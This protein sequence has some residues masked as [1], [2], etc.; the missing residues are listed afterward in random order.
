MDR[1]TWAEIDLNNVA[2]NVR[3]LKAAIGADCQL[4]AVVKANAYGH[5]D[6]EVATTAL[7]NG[8]SWL[9]VTMPEEGLRLRRAGIAAPILVLGGLI[10]SQLE[11]CVAKDLVITV[12]QWD[13]AQAL[14]NIAVRLRK[15]ARV[16]IKID[17]GMGRTGLPPEQGLKFIQQVRN[18]PGIEVQGIFTHFATAD[19][20]EGEYVK[21]QWQKFSWLLLELKKAGIHI[22][23]KHCA[24]TAATMLLPETHLDLVRVG[25]GLYGLY[26]SHH[27]PLEL[28]PALSL[29]SK[30]VEVKRVPAGTGVSYGY[31]YVTWRETTI[32]TLP[33]GYADGMSRLLSNKAQVLINSKRFP[34]VGKITMDYCMVDVGDCAVQVGDRVTLIGSQ[35]DQ[36]IT[37]DQW[38]DW[39][40]TISYEITCM[41]TDRVHRVYLK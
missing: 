1:P 19:E 24:N 36:S 16:H 22:P 35:G 34:V 23:I 3:Q 18:L 5:G 26:P 15:N 6:I 13:I 21:L 29:H 32:A 25:L 31:N 12:S 28:K 40:N 14:S 2:H 39:L 20:P 11:T 7:A 41:L 27:R 33:I 37:V 4:L 10:S 17:T 9:A 8:A 38:A 30:V